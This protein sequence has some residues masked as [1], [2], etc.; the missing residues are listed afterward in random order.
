MGKYGKELH[1]DVSSAYKHTYNLVAG[2]CQHSMAYASYVRRHIVESSHRAPTRKENSDF[3]T[4]MGCL[5]LV[6]LSL[7]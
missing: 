7:F 3:R 4:F 2:E 1:E 6:F 5:K